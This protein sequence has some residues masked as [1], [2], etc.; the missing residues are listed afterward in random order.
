VFAGAL[1]VAGCLPFLG[2]ARQIPEGLVTFGRTWQFNAGPFAVL[3]WFAG[4]FCNDPSL[5]ARLVSG[6]A[7]LVVVVWLARRD[8]G[9]AEGFPNFGVAALGALIILG[10]T[11]MPWY[12][13]VAAPA[14][15][16]GWEAAV[17]LFLGARL[18]FFS[19]YG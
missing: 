15:G 4:K 2:A 14:G 8:T 5:I 13:N 3:Q 9:Q 1:I 18:S 12:V 16:L 17:G 6:L 7:V 11:V 10:P 19:S